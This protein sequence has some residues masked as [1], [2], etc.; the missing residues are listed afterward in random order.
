MIRD[1]RRSRNHSLPVEARRTRAQPIPPACWPAPGPALRCRAPAA[2]KTEAS[3]L[4]PRSEEHTS[5]LQSLMRIS[6]AVLCLK[7]KDETNQKYVTQT[8]TDIQNEG[9]IVTTPD[10]KTIDKKE[11]D[12]EEEQI[13]T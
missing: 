6:Y 12:I 9:Q 3:P 5:E 13:N 1:H 2:H 4:Q 10:T 8:E 7:K 11:E